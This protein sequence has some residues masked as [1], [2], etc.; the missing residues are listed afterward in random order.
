MKYDVRQHKFSTTP[1]RGP[2]QIPIAP[3][4]THHKN[5][6][7]ALCHITVVFW[8][9]SWG[10][11]GYFSATLSPDY[12]CLVTS[13]FQFPPKHWPQGKHFDRKRDG[14]ERMQSGCEPRCQTDRCKHG[15]IQRQRLGD[16]T[17]HTRMVTLVIL[18]CSQG[19]TKTSYCLHIHI[20]MCVCGGIHGT[21]TSLYSSD[22]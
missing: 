9:M 22:I 19:H 3:L 17:K 4:N 1:T 14:G 16:S 20:F 21:F 10:T 18:P 7:T 5:I 12:P 13:Y 6:Y 8:Q 2:Q 15:R 11:I